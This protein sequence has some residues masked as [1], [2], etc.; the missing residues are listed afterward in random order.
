ME[1]NTCDVNYLDAD[2]LLP[3][4]KRLLAGLKRQ[5]SDLNSSVP[6][7]FI[8][9]GS[10]YSSRLNNLLKAQLSKS[11]LSNEEIAEASR[12]A[13]IEAAKVAEVAR[14]NAE[15]KA[16]KAAI[17]VAAAK[18]ALELVSTLT[19]N[20]A[21][22]EKSSKKN[23][24]KKQVP[25]QALYNKK[26]TTNNRT[27]EELA[28]NLHRT[29][30]SSPRILKNSGSDPKNHKHKRL[31]SSSSSGKSSIYNAVPVTEGCRHSTTTSSN[32]LVEVH[33]E[34]P[35]KDIDTIMVDL[36]TTKTDK[37]DQPRLVNGEGFRP[38]KANQVNSANGEAGLVQSKNK[39]TE[40]VDSFSKKRGR[41]KQK[42]LPLSICSF[43]DQTSPKELKSKA[44]PQSVDNQTLYSV[45]PSSNNLMP[46]ERPT[47]WK[48][49]AFKAPACVK[50]NKV[51]Q[52]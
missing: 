47:V 10:E 44:M 41:I 33:T 32:G 24:M 6:S 9:V 34:A 12:F 36:N 39:F 13:A 7:S 23:K 43:R 42:K 17:A 29:I 18:S 16:A 22:E 3:P 15:E 28:R 52:S 11:N 30:N 46:V 2:A 25:V 14:A 51:M 20:I 45:G 26:G 27:D 40:P 5:T 19:E 37:R 21:T 50:Q 35:V 8:N 31:K 38:N 49:Q 1:M 4:R 48:C